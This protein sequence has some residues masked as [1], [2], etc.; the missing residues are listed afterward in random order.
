[1]TVFN[2]GDLV[3][4][5][6][7]PCAKAV[8]EY[9]PFDGRD[10][11]VVKM[12]DEPTDPDA[13]RTFTALAS[14]MKKAP[15]FA[16]GDKVT[17]STGREGRLVAG[18][19]NSRFG[20]HRFWVM[21]LASGNHEAPVEDALTKVDEPGIK[22][23]DRVR[24]VH[25]THAEEQHGKLGTVTST[26]ETWT[27]RGSNLHPYRV[28]VDGESGD[29]FYVERLERVDEADTYTHNGVD[30]DLSAKYRDT[31]GDVWKFERVGDEV[32]GNY[33]DRAVE[34][35]DDTLADVARA[36]GPLTRV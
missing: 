3:T 25:A 11:Y 4:L 5:R 17:Q 2:V 26:S 12:V 30:Y 15:A 7:R 16:V 31:D 20:S 33:R 35:W 10:V 22:V 27:P 6:T 29:G 9:G 36:Y 21:E 23:G 28:N 24:V 1:V 18:P 32:R 19:F 8:V 34:E 13:V 14:A